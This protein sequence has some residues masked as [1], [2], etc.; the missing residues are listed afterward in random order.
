MSVEESITAEGMAALKADLAQLEGEA[1]REVAA[2][3]Q[4]A[5]EHGDLKENAEYHAAKEE[6]A[7]LESRIARLV[8]RLRS[9]R[10]VE[11]PAHSMIVAFGSTVHVL[12]EQTEREMAFT[13]VGPTEAD[14][15]AGRLSSESP[16]AQALIGHA[17]GDVIDVDT[18]RGSRRWRV[19]RLD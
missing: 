17:P 11:S 10:V 13:I 6:Q 16:M 1:R 3:I 15:G 18:P 14:A 5:R 2:R 7:M 4:T 19:Q 8:A 12:D 9:A